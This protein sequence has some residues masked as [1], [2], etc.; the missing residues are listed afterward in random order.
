MPRYQIWYIEGPNA[1]LKK[2]SER[3]VNAVSFA[4]ALA[5]FT[6]WPVTENYNHRTASAWN[7]GTCLYYQQGWEARLLPDD[8]SQSC[9]D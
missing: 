1:S 7:P 4:E 9:P 2:S 8:E 3:I 6:C 5:P